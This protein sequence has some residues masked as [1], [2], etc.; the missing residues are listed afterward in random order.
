M[1]KQKA[2]IRKKFHPT[3]RVQKKAMFDTE[4][5]AGY[6][7][8]RAWSHDPSVNILDIHT[9][10]CPSCKKWHFGHISKYEQYLAKQSQIVQNVQGT[11]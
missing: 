5:E 7:M 1:K 11:V 6:A 10:V 4:K 8:R 2:K 9:Y 3:C